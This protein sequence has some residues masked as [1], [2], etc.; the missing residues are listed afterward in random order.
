[1]RRLALEG[2][3]FYLSDG[4]I[5]Q[6]DD[7]DNFTIEMVNHE[8]DN[9]IKELPY[10]EYDYSIEERA[11]VLEAERQAWNKWME[12]RD[13]ILQELPADQRTVYKQQTNTIYRSKYQMIKDR[14]NKYIK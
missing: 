10:H 2:L 13:K 11:T 1:M 6:E 12:V 8:Y 5:L 3:L 14:N 7:S 9:Y 4:I